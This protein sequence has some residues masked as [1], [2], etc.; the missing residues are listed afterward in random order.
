MKQAIFT[1]N[2]HKDD[3]VLF[4]STIEQEREDRF[5]AIKNRENVFTKDIVVDLDVV[6]KKT[7]DKL[8]GLE[9]L[10]LERVDCA[11]WKLPPQS[12]ASL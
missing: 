9:K 1:I 6:A 10:S 11:I 12:K 4:A 3:F 8:D 2:R 7:W 5:H